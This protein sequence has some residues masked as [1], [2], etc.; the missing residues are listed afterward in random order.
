M[1]RVYNKCKEYEGIIKPSISLGLAIKYE[2]T[3]SINGLKR[4]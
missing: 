1:D 4:G 3:Q 2:I